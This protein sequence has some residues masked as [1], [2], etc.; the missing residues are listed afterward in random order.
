M[1]TAIY[2][3]LDDKYIEIKSNLQRKTLHRI[4]QGSNFF[5]EIFSNRENVRTPIQLENKDS[6]GILKMVFH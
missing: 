4:N 1:K 2:L 6:T 3:R 5:G